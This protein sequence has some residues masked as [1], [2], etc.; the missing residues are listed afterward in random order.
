MVLHTSD[1][2]FSHH[3]PGHNHNTLARKIRE[4]S[5]TCFVSSAPE[6]PRW[7]WP[8]MT[9]AKIEEALTLLMIGLF[10]VKPCV[11]PV[12]ASLEM[13]F[14]PLIVDALLQHWQATLLQD[15]GHAVAHD[16]VPEIGGAIFL[17]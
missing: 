8:D 1:I 4:R 13:A 2:C 9:T 10:D 17:L 12:V 7:H 11:R 3:N 15:G 14:I 6:T 16:R 5:P